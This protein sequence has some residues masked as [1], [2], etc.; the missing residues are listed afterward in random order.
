MEV[1]AVVLTGPSKVEL[2]IRAPYICERD[3]ALV[4]IM[5]VGVCATDVEIFEGTLGYFAS[6]IAHWPMVPGHEWAGEIVALGS[7]APPHLSVG[8]RVV[9]EH[10]LGCAWESSPDSDAPSKPGFLKRAFARG[11]CAVCCDSTSGF[12]RCPQRVE[13]G[14]ARRDG[15]FQTFMLYPAAQ[16]LVLPDT[17]P[18]DMA[19]L[20]EPLATVFKGVRRLGLRERGASTLCA[21][22]GDGPIGLLALQVLRQVGARVVV[23]A[24]ASRTRLARAEAFGA[25]LTWD[26]SAQSALGLR[27]ELKR[28]GAL[29]GAVLEV[30]GHPSAVPLACDIVQPGGRVVLLGLSG[31]KVSEMIPDDI[32]LK[33]VEL[34]GSLSSEP[35]DWQSAVEMISH[36]GLENIVTH[37]LIGLERYE[38]AL[39][40]VRSPPDGM[41]KLQLLPVHES[42]ATEHSD[43][44]RR[45]AEL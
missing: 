27:E 25:E 41:L 18:W 43:K 24:G 5:A 45:L 39:G 11:S 29:P 30:A 17:V 32:V 9:G 26:V 8:N 13:T 14:V 34:H 31:G 38:E 2:Q 15:A 22:V 42:N 44:K 10:G 33:E 19:A 16:L 1:S 37:T 6:G 20:A 12:L 23:V 36:G 35:E 40:M 21:V 4:K 28:R 3:E 7:S